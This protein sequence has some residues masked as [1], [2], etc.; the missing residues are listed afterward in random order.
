MA[1]TDRLRLILDI[2]AK[3][4]A[5]AASLLLR[6]LVA[7]WRDFDKYYDGDLVAARAARS[8]SMVDAATGAI[9]Q[10]TESY[11]RFAYQQY[12]DLQFPTEEEIDAANDQELDRL[13]NP[14]DEWNRPAEQ[15]R[16]AQSQGQERGKAIEVA[17]KRVE[18]LADLDMAL[19]MRNMA[20]AIIKATPKVTGYRRVIH[21][22]L[23]ESGTSCGLCIAA[24][25]RVYHKQELMPLHDHCHCTVM[26]IVGDEDPGDFFNQEDI[27][28]LNQL[29]QAANG[30]DAVSLSRTR[31]KVIQNSETGPYLVEQG[32][33]TKGNL[34]PGSPKTKISREDS[35]NAQIKSLTESLARL[36]DRQ[37][38]GEDVAEPIVW[39]Q[40]RLRLLKSEQTR[41]TRA[42]RRR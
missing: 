37:R 3:G 35:V 30:N 24:S 11:L 34:S 38:K 29:Y 7:L 40:D 17:T 23:S 15:F 20:S 31:F 9:R 39:Q 21:P 2:Q 6:Q 22:E 42:R 36:L 19:A 13:V 25:T 26:P 8:A 5:L 32:S 18:E 33:K 10:Q 4:F 27:D 41:A 16:F 28:L 12:D 14:L 1:N